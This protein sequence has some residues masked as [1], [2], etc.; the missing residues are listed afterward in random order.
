MA[1]SPALGRLTRPA[2][3]MLATSRGTSFALTSG[4]ASCQR[5]DSSSHKPSVDG[6][7]FTSGCA[8]DPELELIGHPKV[9]ARHPALI[10]LD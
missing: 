2:G 5:G 8:F 7:S 10:A 1:G 3:V 6:E 4:F 9:D